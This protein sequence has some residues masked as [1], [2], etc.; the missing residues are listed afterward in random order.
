MCTTKGNILKTIEKVKR[1]ALEELKQTLLL[2]LVHFSV[3]QNKKEISL[4]E[5]KKV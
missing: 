3:H 1:W 4:R 2:R 5:E